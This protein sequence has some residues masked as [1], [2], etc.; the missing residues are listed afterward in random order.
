M[1]YSSELDEVTSSL[2][3]GSTK[4]ISKAFSA[5]IRQSHD[6]DKKGQDYKIYNSVKGFHNIALNYIICCTP[7]SRKSSFV[8]T[9]NGVISRIW[10]V[11]L[12]S[13]GGYGEPVWNELTDEEQLQLEDFQRWA[14][15]TRNESEAQGKV[16][17]IEGSEYV[18]D[19]LAKWQEDIERQAAM[20]GDESMKIFSRRAKDDVNAVGCILHLLYRTFHSELPLKKVKTLVLKAVGWMVDLRLEETCNRYCIEPVKQFIEKRPTRNVF[21]LLS[22]TFTITQLA[23]AMADAGLDQA[24]SRLIRKWQNMEMVKETGKGEYK[25]IK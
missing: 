17:E 5:W 12:N 15:D 8:N 21:E 18:Y 1:C 25:K 13:D 20:Y 24:P 22:E 14:I 2:M 23:V 6:K 7:G 11:S 19:F 4:E 9:D 3:A 16:M 10:F